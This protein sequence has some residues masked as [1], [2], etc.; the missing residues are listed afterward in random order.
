M[1]SALNQCAVLSRFPRFCCLDVFRYTNASRCITI[2]HGKFVPPLARGL[3]VA[4]D[5]IEGSPAQIRKLS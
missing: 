1:V 2:A 5:G 4:R 3:G